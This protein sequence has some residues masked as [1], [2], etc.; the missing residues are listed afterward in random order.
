M[1]LSSKIAVSVAATLTGSIDLGSKTSTASL[2]KTIRLTNGTGAN[3]ADLIWQDTRTLAASGTENLDLAGVLTDAFGATLT[4][5]RIKAVVVAAAAGNTNNVN[6]IREG[7]NGVPLFLAAGDG[8][9]VRPGGAFAWAATDA[10]GVA[11]TAGTGD[12]LTVTNS[13][14]GSSVTYDIVIIGA[15]A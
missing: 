14:A 5:A 15:S 1:S 4:F 7:T 3:Q 8:V 10:T 12:L 2:A 9:P 6:V 11:V 13:G